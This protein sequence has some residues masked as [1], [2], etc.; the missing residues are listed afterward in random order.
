MD[1]YLDSFKTEQE[2]INVI[3]QETEIL[4]RG[5]FHL[6]KWIS[7]SRNILRSMPESEL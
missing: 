5:G 2:S 1:D 7:N 3:S 6:T 4:K